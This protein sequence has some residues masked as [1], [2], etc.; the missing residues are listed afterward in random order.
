LGVLVSIGFVVYTICWMYFDRRMGWT[1]DWKQKSNRWNDT[2]SIFWTRYKSNRI[3]CWT[4]LQSAYQL[5]RVQTNSQCRFC[6]VKNELFCKVDV[7]GVVL[8]FNDERFCGSYTI[9]LKLGQCCDWPWIIRT[10]GLKRECWVQ[11]FVELEEGVLSCEELCWAW[12]RSVELCRALLS[13][14]RVCWAVQSLVEFE[15]GVLSYAELCWAWR[16]GAD[17]KKEILV[18]QIRQSFA[19]ATKHGRVGIL[20]VR[21]VILLR[22]WK[23]GR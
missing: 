13:L 6:L 1:A 2:K 22:I 7:H 15:K 5:E 3:V 20:S 19:R 14:E 16:G 21:N 18:W 8:H 4:V 9:P 12:R 23:N 11:S 10:V 17:L